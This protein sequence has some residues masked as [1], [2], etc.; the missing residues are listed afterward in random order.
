MNPAKFSSIVLVVLA[1]AACG[2]GPGSGGSLQVKNVST[3]AQPPGNVAAYFTVYTKEGAPI[4]DL[5]VP[6]F[7][8]YENDKLISE[9]KAKRSLLETKP[10]EAQY[11]LV[12]VD[13]SGPI[14]DGEDYPDLI[15]AV[16]KLVDTIG[17]NGGQI[18]VSLFD[19]EEEIVPMLG[20]GASGTRAAMDAARHFR[21]RNR[22]GNLNGAIIQGLDA[23]EKQLDSATEP[24]RYGTL[25]IV[26][27]RGDLAK[28]VPAEKAKKRIADSPADVRL[29][30]IGPK[31]DRPQLEA[32]V[33]GPTSPD[34]LVS[35]QP[36]DFGKFLTTI[37]K[38]LDEEANARYL[39]SY[40]SNK[41]EGHHTLTLVVETQDDR[42]RIVYKFDAD[43]FRAGCSSK[44]RP[45]FDK[46][47]GKEKKQQGAEKE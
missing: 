4:T 8:I 39:F 40:C 37:A 24:F 5:D 1:A 36:K 46:P 16:G 13:V 32:L 30:A 35:D 20:F 33:G 47:S 15:T 11:V 38:K 19:G 29:V 2:S 26:T 14:V 7:K 27:D 9:K 41:R 43:G 10:V 45:V 23:L 31:V 44:H 25:V 42:G 3:V 21:P 17:K 6:N 34:L 22:N 18:A 12:L 28:K